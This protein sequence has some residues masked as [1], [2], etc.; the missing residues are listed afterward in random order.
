MAG[1]LID[2]E[3]VDQPIPISESVKVLVDDL[4]VLWADLQLAGNCLTT[5]VEENDVNRVWAECDDIDR[6]KEK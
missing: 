3:M 2:E 1:D 4:L 5:V 6:I